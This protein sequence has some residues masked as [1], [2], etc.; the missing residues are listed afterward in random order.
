MPFGF[1]ILT[2]IAGKVEPDLFFILL[3]H[4]IL[5]TVAY[6]LHTDTD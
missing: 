4:S 6:P 5:Y 1:Q 3:I 2:V